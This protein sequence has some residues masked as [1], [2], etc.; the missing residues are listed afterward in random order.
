MEGDRV[1]VRG[2]QNGA[3]GHQVGAIGLR[4]AQRDRHRAAG[5]LESP[6]HGQV[7]AE[8]IEVGTDGC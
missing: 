7:L 4:A 6:R 8:Q 2:D 1:R 5:V 3:V